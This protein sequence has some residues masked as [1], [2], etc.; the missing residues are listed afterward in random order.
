MVSQEEFV[1][2]KTFISQ[3]FEQANKLTIEN[4]AALQTKLDTAANYW[5]ETD[6]TVTGKLTMLEQKIAVLETIA[7]QTTQEMGE[8]KLSLDEMES[9]DFSRQITHLHG[10]LS[11]KITLIERAL[12]HNGA[13]WDSADVKY[14]QDIAMM[15]AKIESSSGSGGGGGGRR[16]P[17]LIDP[18]FI[19]INSYDGEG[20]AR[21][22]F[23]TWR[24]GFENFVTT[25][26]PDIKKVFK[27]LRHVS[28]EVDEGAFRLAC[29]KAGVNPNM[30]DW[31]Y[32]KA[33]FELNIFLKLKLKGDALKLIRGTDDGFEVYHLLNSEYDKST[34]STQS[35]LSAELLKHVSGPSKTLKELKKKLIDLYG[36]IK[37]FTKKCGKELDSTLIGS[38]LTNMLDLQTKREFMQETK[39]T[40]TE[41]L[42]DYKKMRSRILELTAEMTTDPMDIGSLE[43]GDKESEEEK[44]TAPETPALS[45]LAPQSGPTSRRPPNPDI[46][47][48]VCGQKGH[49]SFLC[50]KNKSEPPPPT[51]R[52]GQFNQKGKGKGFTK[53][54][55]AGYGG[56]YGQKGGYKGYPNNKGGGKG[57]NS[58]DEWAAWYPEEWQDNQQTIPLCSMTECEVPS[59]YPTPAESVAAPPIPDPEFVRPR[60]TC[61]SSRCC[62]NCP[63]NHLPTVTN[64]ALSHDSDDEDYP[65]FSHDRMFPGT[66]PSLANTFSALSEPDDDLTFQDLEV[67]DP[68][69]PQPVVQ[70]PKPPAS[71]E[72]CQ[73]MLRQ[74]HPNLRDMVSKLQKQTR[75][76]RAADLERLG[77]FDVKEKAQL[78]VIGEWENVEF[79]ADSGAAESV[80][81]S[82]A[83]RS[84][85]T[86]QGEKSKRGV[87]Y[88]SACGTTLPNEGEKRCMI[89]TGDSPI[90]KLAV[91]QV[92]NI[93]KSLLSVSKMVDKGNSVV[94]APS[95]AYIYNEMTGESTLLKRK[96]NLY[97][98][99]AWVRSAK[100]VSPEPQ[101]SSNEGKPAPVFT[102]QGR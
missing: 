97:V 82:T 90:E 60:R 12:D 25:I 85:K 68:P 66:D 78:N 45:P 21:H 62:G 31:S 14:Q 26:F 9:A 55:K 10:A 87:E 70:S 46:E 18:K 50:P 64:E 75:D 22:E 35:I 38:I 30:L 4:A 5:T 11:E 39:N 3:Q 54:G 24:E 71:E 58:F 48:W 40:G 67:S 28:D 86:E 100:P 74:V 6:V 102:R 2:F 37:F 57:M 53:G 83:L 59:E 95:G 77:S 52:P 88:E 73:E 32:E 41:I 93:G 91:L 13:R 34:I 36:Y 79:T 89:S 61:R 33:N 44:P 20:K 29:S 99:D 76:E 16:G 42:G 84:V 69:C 17:T 43:K 63:P 15:N 47:C 56:K 80:V 96:G 27:E 23:D 98:L 101:P 81:P 7:Q 49:P 19:Q 1:Q 65:V 72:A 51:S 94:F 92:A 8:A